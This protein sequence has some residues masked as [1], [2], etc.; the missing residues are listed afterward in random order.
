[1]IDEEL[2]IEEKDIDT[3]VVDDELRNAKAELQLQVR[4]RTVAACMAGTLLFV[5]ASLWLTDNQPGAKLVML[6]TLMLSVVWAINEIAT[7]RK[8]ENG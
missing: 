2:K 8:N 4:V 1:M 5:V 3:F 6:F 7:M